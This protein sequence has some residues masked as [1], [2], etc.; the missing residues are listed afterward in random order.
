[1]QL[2]SIPSEIAQILPETHRLIIGEL[3]ALLDLRGNS[4][5]MEVN[6]EEAA[7]ELIENLSFKSATFWYGR[8]ANVVLENGQWQVTINPGQRPLF[9][10]KNKQQ[11]GEIGVNSGKISDNVALNVR[12]AIQK[13][14]GALVATNKKS[15]ESS[16]IGFDVVP[17]ELE[18]SDNPPKAV[19]KFP[20]QSISLTEQPDGVEVRIVE[21]KSPEDVGPVKFGP[22][23]SEVARLCQT[24]RD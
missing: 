18:I 22:I 24:H 16:I 4:L 7:V 14:L 12:D 1:M 11:G 21:K 9:V 23:F 5:V 19:M 17:D 3:Y 10:L 6:T 13:I 2:S 15:E 8:L 20:G